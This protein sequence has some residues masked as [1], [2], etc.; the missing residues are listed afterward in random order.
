MLAAVLLGG[1]ALAAAGA[2]SVDV[3]MQ[4]ERFVPAEIQVK[5]GATVRWL[6]A[7]KRTSHSLIFPEEKHLPETARLFPGESWSRTFDSAGRYPYVCGPHP[8]MK[9]VVVV[10]P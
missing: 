6:N 8:E 4:G 2:Q 9:G 5:A 7:E 3:R 1:Y 10:L